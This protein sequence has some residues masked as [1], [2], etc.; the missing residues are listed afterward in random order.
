MATE[1]IHESS[2]ISH[3]APW[4]LWS[5]RLIEVII[6]AVLLIAGLLKA[7]QPLDFI[8][9]ITDYRIV[10]APTLVK[11]IAWIAITIECALGAALIVGYKRRVVMP[12]TIGLFLIFLSAIGWAWYTGATADCGCF[13]SW[14]KRTPA[15]AFLED[16][17][18]LFAAGA[19]W[20]LTR[21]EPVK[22][23]SLRLSAV[24]AA[25]IAGVAITT[26]ASNSQRQSSDPLARLQAQT[27]LPSPFKDLAITGLTTDIFHGSH[28]VA[29]IDTGCDHC[30]A[31]VPA[32]NQLVTQLNGSTSVAALCSNKDFEVNYFQ[33]KFNP[34][35][36]IGRI[37]HDDFER[38][39]ERGKPPRIF[40]LRDS[41]VVKIWDGVVPSESEVKSLAPR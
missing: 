7:Y 24:A 10:T 36:P 12:A 19:A 38:L 3:P 22:F 31:S 2:Y 35:F 8:Q 11:V 29:L 15:E 41:A 23:K 37:S 28:V 33:Q 16:M 21:Y 26:L 17:L 20:L 34:Q 6:G 14:V 40:L 25:V 30:Q 9:Q 13:G 5:A 18:L 39:F 32:L 1:H 4:R 27:S